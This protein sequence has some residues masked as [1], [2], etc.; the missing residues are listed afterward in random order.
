M[1][2]ASVKWYGFEKAWGSFED[3]VKDQQEVIQILLDM[4]ADIN[5]KCYNEKSALHYAL[6]YTGYLDV[7]QKKHPYLLTKF[8]L[9]RGADI[10]ASDNNDTTVLMLAIM[11]DLNLVAKYLIRQ[12]VNI[13]AKDNLGRTALVIARQCY[14]EGVYEMLRKKLGG[15]DESGE[16]IL[17]FKE[18]NS[19]LNPI[20]PKAE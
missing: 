2:I 19:D 15:K 8:L 12:K 1:L 14:L 9:D 10:N 20:I 13:N 16:A 7:K 18:L 4:G 5:A 17:T 11:S 3:F 6:D